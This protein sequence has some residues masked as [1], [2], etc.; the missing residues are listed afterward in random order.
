MVLPQLSARQA[1]RQARG[2]SM[3][4]VQWIMVNKGKYPHIMGSNPAQGISVVKCHINPSLLRD[5]DIL[6]L[7]PSP[8][9]PWSTHPPL[10]LPAPDPT[11]C[12]PLLG[13]KQK[14]RI[15][16]TALVSHCSS[17]LDAHPPSTFTCSRAPSKLVVINVY[18]AHWAVLIKQHYL[19]RELISAG[20]GTVRWREGDCAAWQNI[21]GVHQTPRAVTPP[22]FRTNSPPP[23]LT[24]TLKCK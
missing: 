11:P 3:H 13:N 16:L 10:I 8:S 17:L 22:W 19:I 12:R 1:N 15:Y 14:Y 5:N 9:A 6:Q 4:A 21:H 18:A 23:N 20:N 7:Q 2:T 24:V